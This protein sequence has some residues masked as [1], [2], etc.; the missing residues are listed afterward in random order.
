MPVASAIAGKSEAAAPMQQRSEPQ[1]DDELEHRR[2]PGARQLVE[3][4]IV[5]LAPVQGHEARDE[6]LL[7]PDE[8]RQI[9]VR[10]QVAA[11]VVI[12][13]MRDVE[14]DFVQPRG[15]DQQL[16]KRS[17]RELPSSRGL[18]EQ[19]RRRRLDARGLLQ[20]DVIAPLHRADRTLARVLVVEPAEHV[21]QQTLA[22]CAAADVERTR[23]PASS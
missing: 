1:Q 8:A 6:L 18:L 19:R 16:P 21:V 2:S 3:E 10:D 20:V 22:E 5:E 7:E 14:P 9:R 23:S 13:G 11:V 4:R 12:A 17:V 15:P